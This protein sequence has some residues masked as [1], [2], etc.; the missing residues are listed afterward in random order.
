M[1]AAAVNR[2]WLPPVAAAV[3]SIGGGALAFALVEHVSFGTGIY[4]AVTTAS[5]VGFGDVVPQGTGGRIVAIG[6]MLTA[7]PALAALFAYLTSRHIRSWMHLM[8]KKVRDELAEIRGTT[9]AAHK[10]AQAA[11]RIAADLY[12]HHTGG[13]HPDAPTD[14]GE[15]Q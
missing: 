6:V 8:H 10:S 2:G 7:I 14:Q 13:D 1:E 9:Q 15:P 5:T 4:W 3:A 12:R 11:H